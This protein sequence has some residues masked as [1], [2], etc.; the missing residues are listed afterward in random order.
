MNLGG[1]TRGEPGQE[2]KGQSTCYFGVAVCMLLSYVTLYE[3]LK[4]SQSIRVRG[5]CPFGSSKKKKREKK[6][7]VVAPK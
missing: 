1:Q 2:E 4:L 3:E 7:N 5:Y 6:I